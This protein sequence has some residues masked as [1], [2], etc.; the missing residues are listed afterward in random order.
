MKQKAAIERLRPSEKADHKTVLEE[1]GLKREV[2]TNGTRVKILEDI[3][4]WANDSS[5][6]SPRVFWLTG[7]AGSGKTTIAYTIAKRFEEGGNVNQHTILGGNFLCSRQFQE[8]QSQTRI[9]PTIAY[10]LA[11]KCKSY[12]N[13]LHVADKFDAVNHDVSSQLKGLLVGPWQLSEATRHPEQPPYLIVIDALDEIMG[14][15]GSAFLRDLLIAID[16][17][18]LRGLKFLVTS[19]S[20]PKVAALCESFASEA[21]CRLQDVPIEEA[22]SDI[23]TYLKT[24]LPELAGSPEFAELGQRAGGLFIYAA[25]AVKY[26]TPLNSITV[27]EQTEMLNDFLSKSYEP[28]SNATSLVDELYRQIMCDT[29]SKLSGKVLARRLCTLY[30]FLCTAERTSASVVAAL[31]LDGDEEA[32]RAVLRDLHAVLYTTQDD[33]VFWYHASFPDFIFTQAR[34]NFR[35]DKEDFTFSCNKLAHH[36][37]LGQSCFG[38]MKSEKF[39]L[40]FNMGNIASS[41]SFDRDNTLE[42][43]KQVDQNINAVLRYSCRHWTH[44]LPS[45]QLIDTDNLRRCISEFLEIRVLFWIEAMNLLGLS[46]QCT[47]MLQSA[48]QWVLKV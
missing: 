26:L 19:R 25:T 16:E 32:V 17:Y 12:A 34:S 40:R 37:L 33:R 14:D 3:A 13:A 31:V 41:F 46:N 11:H 30:T 27:G 15:G 42:L 21:V 6:A 24:Q 2:C 1:Q 38:I 28:K 35:I 23:E 44:H 36:S 45:P 48:S 47:P 20:D 43:S 29:F 4:K 18:D 22:K 8:T 5:L 9:L 39:G 10:Q 7:Q